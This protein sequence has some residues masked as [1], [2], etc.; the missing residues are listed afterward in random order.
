MFV[1]RQYYGV[2]LRPVWSY[3]I[4]LQQAVRL[5]PVWSYTITLQQAVRL[6][7]R[8]TTGAPAN[9]LYFNIST[10]FCY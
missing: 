7:G 5:R 10:G 1:E 2:R 6:R 8:R 4:A 9:P 3:T